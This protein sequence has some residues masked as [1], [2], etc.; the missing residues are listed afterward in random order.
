MH[1]LRLNKCSKQIS[2]IVVKLIGNVYLALHFP[3]LL[4]SNFKK[5]KCSLMTKKVNLVVKKS[6]C[7]KKNNL[8][9]GFIPTVG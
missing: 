9:F 6:I 7:K 2:R 3:L 4:I 1:V 5:E 8:T